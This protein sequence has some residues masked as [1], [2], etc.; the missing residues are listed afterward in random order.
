MAWA[1]SDPEFRQPNWA[2]NGDVVMKRKTILAVGMLPPPMGGQ[3]LMFKRA[4][5]ALQKHYDLR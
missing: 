1:L 3:A 4:V 2:L 5:D